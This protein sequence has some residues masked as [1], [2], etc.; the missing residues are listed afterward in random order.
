MFQISDKAHKKL[1]GFFEDNCLDSAV[2]VYMEDDGCGCGPDLA[3]SV[4]DAH[5]D[6]FRFS[7]GGVTYA[8]SPE[9]H[10]SVGSVSMDCLNDSCEGGFCISTERPMA[11]SESSCSSCCCC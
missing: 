4:A 2:R 8:V 10:D 11:F 7:V 6:D 1:K 9:L 5:E 3:L